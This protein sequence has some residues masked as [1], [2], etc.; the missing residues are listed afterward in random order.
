M[1]QSTAQTATAPH[2]A[3]APVA[4]G[5]L[6]PKLSTAR[7][8][9]RRSC[10]AARNGR[11]RSCRPPL[12]H[13]RL[14]PAPAPPPSSYS[15]FPLPPSSY[16]ALPSNH[17]APLSNHSSPPSNH[18]P[19]SIPSP[20]NYSDPLSSR[21]EPPSNPARPSNPSSCL[22]NPGDPL[23]SY[24]GPPSNCWPSH[25]PSNA[26][27]PAPTCLPRC[28]PRP[29]AVRASLSDGHPPPFSRMPQALAAPRDPL[30][31]P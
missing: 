26:D 12:W 29:N 23:S 11:S 5:S 31:P 16:S 24:S 3:P 27:L 4:L 6:C 10:S 13:H 21:S 8:D 14:P 28:P 7:G 19:A 18:S 17:F 22:S 2:T 9:P 15:A 25:H 30:C 1:Q 20:P